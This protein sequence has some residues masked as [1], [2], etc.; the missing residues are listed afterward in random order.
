MPMAALL[1]LQP[2]G[3]VER[4]DLGGTVE[5]M[6]LPT[7]RSTIVFGQFRLY[8][9]RLRRGFVGAPDVIRRARYQMS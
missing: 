8:S 6:T 2:P 7:I 4:P 1:Q 3:P 9:I 5:R